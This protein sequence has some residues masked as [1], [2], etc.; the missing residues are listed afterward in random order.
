MTS[1]AKKMLVPYARLNEVEKQ[2]VQ[3]AWSGAETAYVP[4]SYYPV[5]VA[6]L[7]ENNAGQ[8]QIFSGGNIQ[9]QS[10]DVDCC[11][12]RSMTFCAFEQGFRNFKIF[13]M[14]TVKKQG[15][16]PC[17]LCRQVLVEL[18]S[19]AKLLCVQ[20]KDNDVQIWTVRELLP[21]ASVR[22][23]IQIE[24]LVESEKDLV[25]KAIEKAK[26]SLSPYTDIADGAAVLAR[27]KGGEEKIFEGMR[28]E[29]SV[30]GGTISATRVAANNALNSGYLEFLAVAV[31][32]DGPKEALSSSTG[33]SG[34]EEFVNISGACLQTLRQFGQS[35]RILNV[36]VS[37]RSVG[38]AT[39]TQLLPGSFGPDAVL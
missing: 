34:Q 37:K 39:I 4:Y 3:K 5:G 10:W 30:Y 21:E 15:G 17:G 31:Y 11:A 7:A 36:S 12:E 35:T 9:N 24:E 1:T 29:N 19:E 23:V 32:A 2:L 16:T 26:F 13:C 14:V 6:V 20:N 33:H 8:S 28:I 27:N 25:S 18:A 22:Q 38:Q